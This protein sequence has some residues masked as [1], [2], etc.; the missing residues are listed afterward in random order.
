MVV[1]EDEADDVTMEVAV[2]RIRDRDPVDLDRARGGPVEVADD[3]SSEVLPEPDGP[4]RT[5]NS[6]G[7]IVRE[8]P[9]T[10]TTGPGCTRRTSLTTTRA[11]RAWQESTLDTNPVVEVLLVVAGLDH[12]PEL[13][14]DAH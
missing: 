11:P 12:D 1:L 6:P 14:R 10:A 2:R 9:S 13:Q 4:V 5:T 8:T 3:D 7:S